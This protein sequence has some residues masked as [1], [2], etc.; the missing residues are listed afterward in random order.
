MC[1][2]LRAEARV[3]MQ[4]RALRGVN[5]GDRISGRG[6]GRQKSG[7]TLERPST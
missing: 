3:R 6:G 4:P 1:D 7:E 5:A 2:S